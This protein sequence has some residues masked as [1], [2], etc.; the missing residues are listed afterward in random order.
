MAGCVLGSRK[1]AQPHPL[2]L[3]MRCQASPSSSTPKMTPGMSPPQGTLNPPSSPTKASAGSTAV[4]ALL[5]HHVL[6]FPTATVLTPWNE[7]SLENQVKMEPWPFCKWLR[8]R[9]CC[10]G[11]MGLALC[12]PEGRAMVAGLVSGK[13]GWW[14]EQVLGAQGSPG[15]GA[16]AC[17]GSEAAAPS[18][19]LTRLGPGLSEAPWG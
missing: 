6:G 19:V 9:C 15:L 14:M 12:W 16:G 11:A 5:N 8:R 13:K 4:R 1:T 3:V 17:V 7:A 2:L 18:V 10:A